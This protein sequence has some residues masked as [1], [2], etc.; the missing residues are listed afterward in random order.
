MAWVYG[1]QSGEFIKIGIAGNISHRMR[2]FKLYNPHPLRVV[3]KQF[4]DNAYF[5]ERRMHKI[6]KDSARGREWF[7]ITKAQAR[8]AYR[9]AIIDLEAHQLK[10][11]E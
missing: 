8:A 7:A 2:M 1:I 4:C 5:V 10:Q 9:Q 11:E 6:L 3:L